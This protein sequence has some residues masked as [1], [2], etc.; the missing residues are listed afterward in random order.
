MRIYIFFLIPEQAPTYI[1][2][3][4]SKT[5][6][7]HLLRISFIREAEHHIFTVCPFLLVSWFS[8]CSVRWFSCLLMYLCFDVFA[9]SSLQPDITPNQSIHVYHCCAVPC[10]AMPC[11]AVPCRAAPRRT[12]PCCTVLCYT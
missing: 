5:A 2:Q 6:I 11:L 8:R 9:F 10:L 12:A 4:D 1:C 7:L 3:S